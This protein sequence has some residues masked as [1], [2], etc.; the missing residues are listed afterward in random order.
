M[1]SKTITSTQ[2]QNN[3]GQILQEVVQRN[4]RF[5]IKRHD[6]A[7]A[8]LISLTDMESL[9][10]EGAHQGPMVDMLREVSPKYLIGE[11]LD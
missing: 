9:L 11:E 3:F 7:Q 8:V 2:A 4:T 5:I 1:T 10:T 6:V